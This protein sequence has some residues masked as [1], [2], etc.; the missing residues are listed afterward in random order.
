MHVARLGHRFLLD[1]HGRRRDTQNATLLCDP[2]PCQAASPSGYM[3]RQQNG[4]CASCAVL[5]S[6]LSGGLQ[7][8]ENAMRL[9][10]KSALVTGGASG[11][12]AEIA[13]R[14]AREGAKVVILDL[15][16]EGAQQVAWLLTH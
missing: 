12:G 10:D 15:N 13:R 1:I 5:R 14:Y 7:N 9:K 6:R 16:G 11:F 8:R 2:G 4:I 3:A